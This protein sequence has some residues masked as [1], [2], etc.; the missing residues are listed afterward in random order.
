[1]SGTTSAPWWKSWNSTSESTAATTKRVTLY[2]SSGAARM[3]FVHLRLNDVTRQVTRDAVS[4][5]NQR[6]LR[7]IA[8]LNIK[9]YQK[10]VNFSIIVRCVLSRVWETI[11][12]KLRV[13]LTGGH[14]WV[15]CCWARADDKLQ[16]RLLKCIV[17]HRGWSSSEKINDGWF[18]ACALK[19]TFKY[20]VSSIPL[21][22]YSLLPAKESQKI[23]FHK[24]FSLQWLVVFSP[25]AFGVLKR[26]AS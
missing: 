12:R 10:T 16:P 19:T 24:A 13:V 7:S 11:H 3:V 14:S 20:V 4:L 9:R 22:V 18:W 25:P 5:T 15:S 8:S 2:A 23:S 1:M 17:H 26:K 21:I 6:L